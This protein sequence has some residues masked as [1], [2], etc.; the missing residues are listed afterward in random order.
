MGK[1]RPSTASAGN[2][3]KQ[4]E[5][6]RKM[7]ERQ[8]H[9]NV[10]AEQNTLLLSRMV[11]VEN[12][13]IDDNLDDDLVQDCIEILQIHPNSASSS[14]TSPSSTPRQPPTSINTPIQNQQQRQHLQ[15]TPHSSQPLN[16][17]TPL[18]SVQRQ[19]FQ[20]ITVSPHEM[21]LN[22]RQPKP[23]ATPHSQDEAWPKFGGKCPWRRQLSSELQ[24]ESDGCSPC[25]RLKQEIQ[26]LRRQ[27]DVYEGQ[28]GKDNIVNSE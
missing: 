8:Q 16:T 28:N 21:Q 4:K 7:E 22:S 11:D 18:Q 5:K 10:L 12:S 13:E 23:L 24:E 3:E 14:S 9:R 1:N 6:E 17:I 26:D 19:P 20:S 2:K 15:S 25:N 27:L